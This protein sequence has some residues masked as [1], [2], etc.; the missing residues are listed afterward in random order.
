M[1]KQKGADRDWTR[2]RMGKGS[3]GSQDLCIF[4]ESDR[5]LLLLLSRVMSIQIQRM[6]I[7][8]GCDM[9]KEVADRSQTHT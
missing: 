5:S 7:F 8:Q 6:S 1:E 3:S 9:Q 2:V 4:S